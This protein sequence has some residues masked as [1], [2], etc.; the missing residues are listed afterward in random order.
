M[1]QPNVSSIIAKAKERGWH[2]AR[3][4]PIYLELVTDKP[5]SGR[6]KKQTDD[7]KARIEERITST[8]EGRRLTGAQISEEFDISEMT[9]LR[10]LRELGFLRV[11]PTVKPGLIPDMRKRRL[12]W[13]LEHR[14]WTLEDWKKVIW[15]DETAVVLSTKRG[16]D[17]VWR[18][19]HEQYDLTVI[20][21]RYK[22]Y[23]T[24]QFWGCFTYDKKGPFHIYGTET[25]DQKRIA[26]KKIEEMNAEREPRLRNDWE[27]N[28]GIRRLS[29]RDL[30]GKK[31]QMEIHQE[32]WQA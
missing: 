13:A 6:P 24:S 8:K 5:R 23:S 10:V 27:M 14:H 20:R 25:A 32:K 3:D 18:R 2:P 4:T 28:N 31:A 15:T 17:Y 12:E 19:P 11:K 7:L 1:T 21:H 22:A 16:G 30:P 9:A 26:T 29:L